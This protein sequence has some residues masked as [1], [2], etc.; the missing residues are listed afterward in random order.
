[1]IDDLIQKIKDKKSARLAL[2]L[3]KNKWA[4]SIVIPYHTS[5]ALVEGLSYSFGIRKMYKLSWPKSLLTGMMS[6]I[7]YRPL[8][9]ILIR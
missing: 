8:A 3:I 6:M 2:F 5:A 1:M 4:S 9:V 7:V